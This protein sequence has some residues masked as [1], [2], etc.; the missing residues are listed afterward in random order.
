M[1]LCVTASLCADKSVVMVTSEPS[2]LMRNW[3]TLSNLTLTTNSNL[4]ATEDVKYISASYP[5]IKL[6]RRP[7]AVLITAGNEYVFQ[8]QLKWINLV[9]TEQHAPYVT[10]FKPQAT[11]YELD[12][13]ALNSFK[14]NIASMYTPDTVYRVSKKVSDA[15]EFQLSYSR[16]LVSTNR[17]YSTLW[18]NAVSKHKKH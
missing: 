11:R 18:G 15:P 14:E 6:E 16:I 17:C 8:L 12:S 2:T 1:N 10:T 3:E 7:G 5:E 4:C 13:D 9:L